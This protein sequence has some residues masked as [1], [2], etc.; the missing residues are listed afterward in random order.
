MNLT[1]PAYLLRR[2]SAKKVTTP[3]ILDS[4]MRLKLRAT[5]RLRGCARSGTWPELPSNLSCIPPIRSSE[6]KVTERSNHHRER[7]RNHSER[8]RTPL[9]AASRTTP[10]GVS[11][12]SERNRNH[13]E[14][15]QTPLRA[16]SNTTRSG[17]S[18]HSERHP[19]RREWYEEPI[20]VVSRTARSGKRTSREV[21]RTSLPWGSKSRSGRLR[22]F[23]VKRKSLF[24]SGYPDLLFTAPPRAGRTAVLPRP[25]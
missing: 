16:E 12:H 3:S 25:L 21:T 20:G 10:S 11:Y 15:Y 9:R 19:S 2:F 6:K 13:S 17:I 24:G 18:Y 7:N 23:F 8:Y 14:R 5:A 1:C 4:D 22:V